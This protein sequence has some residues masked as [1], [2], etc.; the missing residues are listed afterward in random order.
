M[1]APAAAAPLCNETAA[2]SCSQMCQSSPL[3]SSLFTDCALVK[4]L[5]NAGYEV[6]DHTQSH[7]SVSCGPG[8]V[9]SLDMRRTGC[10]WQSVAWQTTKQAACCA[11]ACTIECSRPLASKPRPPCT[12]AEQG[13]HLP[14]F[15]PEYCRSSAACPTPKKWRRLQTGLDTL[16]HISPSICSSAACRTRKWRRKSAR[17][18]ASWQ[19]AASRQPILLV[20][21][22]RCWRRTA[23]RA[24]R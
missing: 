15:P 8:A 18:G 21:G 22:G 13:A 2:S 11:A 12:W 7:I 23:A 5:Y 4:K 16:C 14:H 20:S 9:A 6:A 17:G 3:P 24:R 1:L 10:L 19:R